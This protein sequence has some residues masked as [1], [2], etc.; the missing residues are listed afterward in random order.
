MAGQRDQLPGGRR[1]VAGL[2]GQDGQERVGEQ[3]QDGPPL[4][5]G[6]APD[7]VLVQGS[8]LFAGSEPVLDL[9]AGSGDPHQLGQRYRGGGAGTVEGV[10]T[11]ADTAADQQ[12]VRAAALGHHGI[13]G[14]D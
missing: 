10:L 4:P 2:T 5:G 8:E 7:L 9:P 14:L 13:S 6:P 3:G 1:A 11:V 12:P